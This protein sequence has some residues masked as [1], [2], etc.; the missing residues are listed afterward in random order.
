M[1]D[2][3]KLE[4][5]AFHVQTEL[6]LGMS[7]ESPIEWCRELVSEILEIVGSGEDLADKSEA[8]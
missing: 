3:Q 7:S 8:S 1:T 4:D 6:G 2:D 5:A